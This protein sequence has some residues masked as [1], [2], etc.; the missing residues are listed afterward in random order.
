MRYPES[1]IKK[2]GSEGLYFIT[3]LFLN[4]QTHPFP[5]LGTLI[6]CNLLV[7]VTKLG[8]FLQSSY[9][10]PERNKILIFNMAYLFDWPFPVADSAKN[11][12]SF[13][14]KC[15]VHLTSQPPRLHT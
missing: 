6:F 1:T 5:L 8:I 9:L 15:I 7:I 3:I 10:S 11:V 14:L 2:T 4:I 13:T 12:Y